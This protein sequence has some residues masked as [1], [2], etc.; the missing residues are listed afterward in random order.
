VGGGIIGL[1]MATVYD[2]LGSAITV[3]ELMDQLIPGADKDLV[4]PL[5]KRISGRYEAIHLQTKVASIEAGS[6]GLRG[7]VEGGEAPEP[8]EYDGVLLSV[9][10]RP[11]GPLIGAQAAGV[12]VDERGFIPVDRQ[13]RTNV[14]HIH[15]IGD[16]VGEPMLAHKATHEAKVAAEVCA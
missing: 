14:P 9:G 1:E 13:M 12:L 5:Q 2:A 16:I 15:A 7:T 11:N 8:Q 10:R 6:N 3:V 4:R